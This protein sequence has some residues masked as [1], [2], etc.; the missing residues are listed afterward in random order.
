MA[1]RHEAPAI[2]Q[3]MSAE[4]AVNG[5][6]ARRASARQTRRQFVRFA[7]GGAVGLALACSPSAAPPAAPAPA[8]PAAATTSAPV[9]AAPTARRAPDVVRRGTLLPAEQLVDPQFYE[10]AVQQLGP[11]R[12]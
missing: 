5:Q 3:A 7:T 12:G 11:Y 1:R 6:S 4:D 10:Y 8:A 9:A 2:T